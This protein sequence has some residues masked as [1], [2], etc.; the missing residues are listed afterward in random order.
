MGGKH[1]RILG[2]HAVEDIS[3]VPWQV[4]YWFDMLIIIMVT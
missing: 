1:N 4:N 3:E 2:G